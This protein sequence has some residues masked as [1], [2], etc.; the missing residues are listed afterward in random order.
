[1]GDNA[2]LDDDND[3]YPDVEDDLPLDPT[4]HLDSDADGEGNNSDKDDDGDGVDDVV[5]FY[6]LDPTRFEYCC[7]KAL[8]VAGGGP[9]FGNA[10]WPATKNMANF[11]YETL[12]VS[13]S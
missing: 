2:D 7:Q 9:Y 10:L 1:M 6:P 4:E 11:A 5:D 12:K 8:V 3:G 13:G